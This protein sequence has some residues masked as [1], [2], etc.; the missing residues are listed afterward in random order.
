M[1]VLAALLGGVVAA[2]GNPGECD[3]GSSCK[4]ESDG[5]GG[6]CDG[7][8]APRVADPGRRNGCAGGD[9]TANRRRDGDAGAGDACSPPRRSPS[10]EPSE[11]ATL[12][13][14]DPSLLK[15]PRPTDVPFTPKPRPRM[16]VAADIHRG[17]DGKYVADVDGCHW[18][19]FGRFPIANTS[20]IEVGMQT[21]C[22]P[23]EGLHFNPRTGEIDYFIT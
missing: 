15:T 18:A 12:M 10:A 7:P 17:D 4:P 2:C 19:E 22:L 8:G 14:P 3:S 23:D 6:Q 9:A 11:T 1:C 16:P 5:R 21:P 20:D 13:P